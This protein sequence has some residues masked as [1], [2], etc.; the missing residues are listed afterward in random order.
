[1]KFTNETLRSAVKLY[2]SNE[3]DA[4]VMFGNINNWNVSNVTDMSKMFSGAHEFNQDIS[5][6]DVSNVT[7]MSK[8]FSGSHE[9]NQ[10]ISQ[11]DVTNVT[12]MSDMFK[13]LH[14]FDQD[15]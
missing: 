12:N 8:M 2:L 9:F 3:Y 6:W 15:I 4:N 14:E 11:W 13:D 10:D 5:K 1:M 7:N